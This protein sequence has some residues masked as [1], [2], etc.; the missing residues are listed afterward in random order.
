MIIEYYIGHEVIRDM[1][2]ALECFES[3]IHYQC[4]S[5]VH[6]TRSHGLPD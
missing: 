3:S 5:C 2:L 4:P 1:N 6:W